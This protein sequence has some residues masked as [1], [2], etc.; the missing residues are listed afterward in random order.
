M[1]VEIP[2]PLRRR[3]ALY[4]PD[5]PPETLVEYAAAYE[6]R[7]RIDD[8]LQFYVQAGDQAGLRRMKSKAL[9]LGDAFLLKALARAEPGMVDEQ[10]WRNMV[11]A[12]DRLGK[13]LYARQARAALEGHLEALEPE[14]KRG[15]GKA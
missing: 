15:Q 9:E 2:D 1:A 6:Q 10:D 14:E 4:G 3:E 12:A 11:A 8:A 7:G 5:T 13:E